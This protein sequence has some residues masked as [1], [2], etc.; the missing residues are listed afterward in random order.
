M[1]DTSSIEK[2]IRSDALYQQ[3][4]RR[5]IRRAIAILNNSKF[6]IILLNDSIFHIEAIREKEIR[7][8]RIVIDKLLDE[9]I[10]LVKE[11][12]LPDICT[13]EIWCKKNGERKFEIKDDF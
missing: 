8:I 5:A 10:K 9:D 2:A 1:A 6:K 13:K 11:I 12:K 3:K 7:K 4:L